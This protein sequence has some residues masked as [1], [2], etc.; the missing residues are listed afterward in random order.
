LDWDYNY[1]GTFDLDWTLDS[2]F[3][4][5]LDW[6]YNYYVT[7]DWSLDW[8]YNYYVTLD[9]NYY[10]NYYDGNYY[11]SAYYGGAV[12]DDDIIA[13]NW[14]SAQDD[15]PVCT[16][17][18]IFGFNDDFY[19]DDYTLSWDYNYYGTWDL[20][21]SLTWPS[22]TWSLTWP[23][24]TWSLSWSLTWPSWTW[25]WSLTWPSWSFDWDYTI[26]DLDYSVLVWGRRNNRRVLEI[27]N[28][29]DIQSVLRRNLRLT[30]D[31]MDY[32]VYCVDDDIYNLDDAL[33]EAL[34]TYAVAL[35]VI[36]GIICLSIVGC[37]LFCVMC[38]GKKKQN[39]TI[40]VAGGG[41]GGATVV[42][43]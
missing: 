11:V 21:W 18:D 41:G 9:W 36:G 12:D 10:A 40:V 34:A 13:R 22:W 39:T 19:Y 8:D 43:P 42:A 24:W 17:D 15:I 35:I 20:S 5:S 27:N 31:T 26:W 14:C 38:K 33:A 32:C 23:S 37:I 30:D 28:Y 1:Y 25:S 7:L 6:D 29:E 4:W 3:D 2:W 16:T